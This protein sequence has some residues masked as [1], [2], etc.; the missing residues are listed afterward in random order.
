MSKIKTTT[1]EEQHSPN[2]LIIND[3]LKTESEQ[4]KHSKG[5]TDES[6][7]ASRYVNSAKFNEEH[8]KGQGLHS[9][10]IQ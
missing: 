9:T 3:T 5:I 1:I 8:V 6:T 2:S 4:A 7:G 10:D